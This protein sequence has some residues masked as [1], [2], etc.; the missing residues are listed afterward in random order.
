MRVK[1]L[2]DLDRF[3]VRGWI[4]NLLIMIIVGKKYRNHHHLIHC[5][6]LMLFMNK[7]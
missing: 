4:I 6:K 5:L 7:V 3:M 1:I 2:L